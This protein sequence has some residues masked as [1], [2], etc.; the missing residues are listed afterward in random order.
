MPGGLALLKRSAVHCDDRVR[1]YIMD[2]LIPVLVNTNEIDEAARLLDTV[3]DVAEEL[4]PVFL[5]MRA[6]VAA[7]QGAD[8]AS[9]AYAHDA[10]EAGGYRGHELKR[11]LVRIL[12]CL[13]AED[14]GIFPPQAFK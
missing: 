10:L 12:F 8:A 9:E 2:L 4:V 7:R 3:G 14:T 6:V 5:A 13:F 1:Q 11:F